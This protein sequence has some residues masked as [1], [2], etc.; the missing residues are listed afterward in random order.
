V[1]KRGARFTYGEA[2][3]PL[4]IVLAVTGLL[5]LVIGFGGWWK[6]SGQLTR[7][8]KIEDALY[9]YKQGVDKA[10]YR[11]LM[12]LTRIRKEYGDND[13]RSVTRRSN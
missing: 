2:M 9:R 3:G 4:T 1:P 8:E 5:L 12:D 10:S 13:Q 6:L 7:E 11:T